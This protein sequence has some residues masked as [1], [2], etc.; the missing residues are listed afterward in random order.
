MRLFFCL[1]GKKYEVAAKVHRMHGYSAHADQTDLID[2]VQNMETRPK[3][4]RLVHGN[5]Q[6]KLILAE[7]LTNLGYEIV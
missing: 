6:P 7:K 3:Q 5:Y 1:N 2:F 4:I